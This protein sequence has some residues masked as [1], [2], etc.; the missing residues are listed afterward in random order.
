MVRALDFGPVPNAVGSARVWVDG[1]I[2]TVRRASLCDCDGPTLTCRDGSLTLESLE[3]L[4]GRPVSVGELGSTPVTPPDLDQWIDRDARWAPHEHFWL[5]RW[6]EPPFTH[7]FASAPSGGEVSHPA[8]ALDGALTELAGALS[9]DRKHAAVLTMA[10]YAARLGAAGNGG[11]SLGFRGGAQAE[12]RGLLYAPTVPLR[13][14]P[15]ERSVTELARWLTREL[16][17]VEG[18]G[19]M[20]LDAMRRH[21]AQPAEV[22]PPPVDVRFLGE[23][24]PAELTLDLDQPNV[25]VLRSAGALDEAQLERVDAH[26]A[27][28]A[29]GLAADP[30]CPLLPGGPLTSGNSSALPVGTTGTAA[31]GSERCARMA[32]DN[33]VI[34][35][36][37]NNSATGITTSR[38]A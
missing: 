17:R 27:T 8:K 25:P 29:R 5:R 36:S 4:D 10:V 34:L 1:T 23:V 35:G 2:L 6:A 3:H 7:P 19:T 20:A 15:A 21:S 26:L 28:L 22:R 37:C 12:A 16:E 38:L 24:P 30:G 11:R 33:W 31:C 18:R 14:A 32:P 9:I 13:P